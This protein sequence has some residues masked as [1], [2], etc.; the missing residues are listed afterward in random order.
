MDI[1]ISIELGEFK[2]RACGIIIVD[3]KILTVKMNNNN[4]Y[5]LPGGHIEL[6]EDS[7]TGVK[8]EILEE[9]NFDVE[10]EKLISIVENFYEK[11]NKKFHELGFYYILKPKDI[12]KVNLNDY[13]RFENDKGFKVRLEFK[14]VNLNEINNIN[15]KPQFLKEKLSKQDFTFFHHINRD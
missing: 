7:M 8:R 11:D 2:D 3:N 1:R 4:F 12:A 6:G 14:W 10:I 9:V 13:V 5:C 15:F